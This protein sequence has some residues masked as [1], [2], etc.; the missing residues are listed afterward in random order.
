MCI[1]VLE[2]DAACL[3]DMLDAGREVTKFVAG[4]RYHDLVSDR[5]LRLAVERELEIIG[6]AARRVSVEFRE[7]HPE[8]AWAAIVAQ[9]N[10]IAHE[11]GDIRLEWIWTVATSRVPELVRILEPLIPPPP[12][13]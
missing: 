6:E 3:W 11:Y 7:R 8:I 10:V 2:R 9:R 4:K 5:M 1:P 13:D 12:D